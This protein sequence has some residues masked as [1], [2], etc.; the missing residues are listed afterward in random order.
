MSRK[1]TIEVS[2]TVYELLKTLDELAPGR[3]RDDHDEQC[4]YLYN[5]AIQHSASHAWQVM[6]RRLTRYIASGATVRV[7]PILQ[8]SAPGSK[9]H[10]R[11]TSIARKRPHP[12][13]R[14]SE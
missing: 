13:P 5:S 1:I 3:R 14:D 7:R 11:R 8:L 2:D 6:Q 9:N 12:A 10:R 4:E